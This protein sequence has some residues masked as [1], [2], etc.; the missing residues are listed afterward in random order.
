MVS[1]ARG[2]RDEEKEVTALLIL[3]INFSLGGNSRKQS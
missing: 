3:V 2:G 1:L